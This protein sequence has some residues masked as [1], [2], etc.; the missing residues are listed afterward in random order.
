MGA[1]LCNREKDTEDK[2]TVTLY[3]DFFVLNSDYEFMKKFLT[4]TDEIFSKYINMSAL[5]FY[6][7]DMSE[8]QVPI[9]NI[10]F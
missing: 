7:N 5:I 2:T 1:H 9:K 10:F 6:F 8:R 4:N 3:N